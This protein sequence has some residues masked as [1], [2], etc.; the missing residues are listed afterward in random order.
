V[1]R[2]VR[3]ADEEEVEDPRA[4]HAV[5]RAEPFQRGP[6]ADDHAVAVHQ[7]VHGHEPRKVRAAQD[8]VL[9]EAGWSCPA[10]RQ[11]ERPAAA[12]MRRVQGQFEAGLP[13]LRLD[14]SDMVTS[15]P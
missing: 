3:P 4:L 1:S 10:R 12:V 2:A 7:H 15:A 14:R 8:D 5:G 11:F 9:V 13:V 6:R